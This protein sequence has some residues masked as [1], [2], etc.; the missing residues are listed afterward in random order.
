VPSRACRFASVLVG[1]HACVDALES[2]RLRARMASIEVLPTA[3][4]ASK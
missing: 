2:R 1:E 3:F 4:M